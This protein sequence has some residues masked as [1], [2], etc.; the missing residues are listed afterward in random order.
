MINN[1][2]DKNN[3]INISNNTLTSKN[4][5]TIFNT[6]KPIKIEKLFNK[7]DHHTENENNISNNKIKITDKSNNISPEP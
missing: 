6:C 7:I 3:I 5:E 4:K 2:L 1:Q